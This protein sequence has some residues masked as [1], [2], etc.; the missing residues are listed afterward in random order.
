MTRSSW[1][2]CAHAPVIFSWPRG[3]YRSSPPRRTSS[4]SQVASV[5]PSGTG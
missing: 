1:S 3:P 4:R 2:I 5:C